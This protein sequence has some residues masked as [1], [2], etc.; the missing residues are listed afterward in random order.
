MSG[1]DKGNCEKCG[2]K[3]QETLY[4][5]C[6]ICGEDLVGD[7]RFTDEEKESIRLSIEQQKEKARI[8]SSSSTN[9]TGSEDC[10]FSGLMM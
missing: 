7:Q 8:R 5:T 9:R 10:D 4:D 6:M 2:Q 3:I 1:I